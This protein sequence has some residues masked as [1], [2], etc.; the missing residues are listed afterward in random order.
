M[1]K[2]IVANQMVIQTGDLAVVYEIR[3]TLTK[4]KMSGHVCD[5]GFRNGE[6]A[7]T[8]PYATQFK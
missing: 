2:L 1:S 7:I 6:H 8:Q 3:M 4:E 5:F